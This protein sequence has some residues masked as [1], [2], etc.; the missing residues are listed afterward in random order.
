MLR[1]INMIRCGQS[2]LN[3]LICR[4]GNVILDVLYEK[5]DWLNI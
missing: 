5:F 3:A 2:Y 1:K 4:V